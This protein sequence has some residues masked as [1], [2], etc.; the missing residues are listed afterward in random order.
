MQYAVCIA[1]I[2]VL[3]KIELTLEVDGW[4]QFSLGKKYGKC[5]IQ[6]FGIFGIFFSFAMHISI[7]SMWVK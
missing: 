7:L 2:Q 5:S 3:K 6:L 4:V 1:Y